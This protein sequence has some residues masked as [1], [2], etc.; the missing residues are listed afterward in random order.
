MAS[1]DPA[2]QV[3]QP[4]SEHLPRAAEPAASSAASAATSDQAARRI[5][6]DDRAGRKYN[7]HDS[8]YHKG[9]PVN[10]V[11]Q[12]KAEQLD[13]VGERIQTADGVDDRTGLL[14]EP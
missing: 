6:G 8:N 9:S 12:R 11:V 13:G 2:V 7:R 10:L 4:L 3:R 14:H 1:P 5:I